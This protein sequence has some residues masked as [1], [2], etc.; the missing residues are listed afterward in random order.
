MHPP[1]RDGLE[2]YL[3]GKPDSGLL[4]HIEACPECREMVRQSE[5]QA[6]LIRSL[7]P[8]AEFEPSAGFYAR[9][10][11]A[12]DRQRSS[13]IWSVFLEP[14]FARRLMV[15]SAMLTL[16]LGVLLFTSPK[17]EINAHSMPEHI[18]AEEVPSAAQLVDLNQDRNAVLVQLTTYS[19]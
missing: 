13:S 4:H 8:E 18:L 17:D 15:A 9:V 11:D 7:R 14:F 5:L 6:Q 3:A 16:L 12:I 19:E 2:A 10:M 1:V